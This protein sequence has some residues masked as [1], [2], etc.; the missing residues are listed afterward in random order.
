MF[1]DAE[2]TEPVCVSWAS[3]LLTLFRFSMSRHYIPGMNAISRQWMAIIMTIPMCGCRKFLLKMHILRVKRQKDTDLA[4]IY[5]FQSVSLEFQMTSHNLRARVRSLRMGI[6]K[7]PT[8]IARCGTG[9]EC[10]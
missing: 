8:E 9:V 10:C 7:I 3:V 6:I 5:N 4:S 2:L 1:E